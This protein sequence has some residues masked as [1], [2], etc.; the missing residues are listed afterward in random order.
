MPL[1]LNLTRNPESPAGP[2]RLHARCL[3]APKTF[4]V[5]VQGCPIRGWL[6]G[7]SSVLN[8]QRR[9][10]T[11]TQPLPIQESHITGARRAP[12]RLLAFL[13]PH[14]GSPKLE[15]TG[16]FWKSYGS[17]PSYQRL[18]TTAPASLPVFE[19]GQTSSVSCVPAFLIHRTLPRWKLLTPQVPLR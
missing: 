2:I 5:R 9:N 12:G 3:P 7:A 13:N 10:P 4:G 18:T 17:A 16:N 14:C 19:V 11:V 6:S 15:K 1:N 8:S